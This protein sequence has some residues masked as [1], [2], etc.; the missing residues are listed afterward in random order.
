MMKK[1]FSKITTLALPALMLLAGTAC[2]DF[3][4]VEPTTSWNN[5][6]FYKNAQ[7]VQLGLTGIYNYLG[8]DDT[9]GQLLPCKFHAGTDEALYSRHTNEGWPVSLYRHSPANLD[10]EKAWYALYR[11]VD[12]ANNFIAAVPSTP[13]MEAKQ[14]NEVVAEARFLRALFYLDLVR[15]WGPVPLRLEPTKDIDANNIPATSVE[16]VYK[17]IIDDLTFAYQNLPSAQ[18]QAANKQIGRANKTAAHGIL[19]RVYITMAGYPLQQTEMFK[20]AAAHCDSVLLDP[21]YHLNGAYNKVFRNYITNQ[22]DP[23]E[24]LFEV[25]FQN[26]RDQ[27][28]NEHGRHGNI[29]GVQFTYGGDGYPYA[30]AYMQLSVKLKNIYETGDSR[31]DW[32][33]ASYA[34]DKKKK[35]IKRITN[36]LKWWPGKFR[37]WEPSNWADV[38]TPGND[39]P[40]EVLEPMAAP[41]KNFTG[42][43]FPIIRYA[44]VL[45]MRA[46]AENEMNGPGNAYTY[47][48]KVRDRAGLGEVNKTRVNDQVTFRKEIQDER[49]RELC[50]EGVRKHDLIR[51]G[52][53]GKTLEELN[54]E[55]E[56]SGDFKASNLGY[57]HL[58]RAGENFD[59]SKHLMLPYPLQEVANNNQLDQHAEWQ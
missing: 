48:N 25:N 1:I 27:G 19:A 9:Y 13:E 43:N 35:D 8:L 3:L 29:N 28:L 51:W 18:E 11:G 33:C 21:L 22:Y 36:E 5:D 31:Y 16:G 14:K 50:F 20:L 32:N 52:I 55:I 59:A 57:T 37:R 47:L 4:E 40:Y 39:E 23:A 6:N 44:D 46:E 24:T 12:A 42:V 2:N 34:Y 54:M 26:L 56:A 38:D 17:A 58:L 45:L 53:L 30:Y 49:L 41:D 10:I 7:E 15:W